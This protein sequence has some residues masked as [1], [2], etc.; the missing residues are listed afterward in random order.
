MQTSAE[1][2]PWLRQGDGAEGSRFATFFCTLPTTFEHVAQWR[3]RVWIVLYE[4]VTRLV[5]RALYIILRWVGTSTL[6]ATAAHWISQ[7]RKR[8]RLTAAASCPDP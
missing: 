4:I 6:A 2:F 5:F 3:D 7:G 8:D 1:R